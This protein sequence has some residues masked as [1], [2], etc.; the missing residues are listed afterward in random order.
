MGCVFVNLIYEPAIFRIALSR[1]LQ[2]AD[3]QD[4]TQQVLL[5]VH[6]KI[7]EWALNQ[8]KG[9]FHGWLILVARNLASK[10]LQTKQQQE[11]LGGSPLVDDVVQQPPDE[12]A[13]VF[14]LEYRKQVLQRAANSI[15]DQHQP[16]PRNAFSRISMDSETAHSVAEEIGISLDSACAGK[17]RIM[18]NLR[19]MVD[20][21]T[22][23]EFEIENGSNE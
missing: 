21:L 10:K 18:A 22:H 4:A 23:E 11:K 12:E 5:A 15:N 16:I 1:G 8:S 14:S 6:K 20:Q 13:W 19:E 2:D 17:C 9:S 3:A 7:P